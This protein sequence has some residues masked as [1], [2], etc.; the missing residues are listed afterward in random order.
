MYL[1]K[2][3]SCC[4]VV[5]LANIISGLPA[6]DG[7]QTFEDAIKVVAAAKIKYPVVFFAGQTYVPRYAALAKYIRDNDFGKVIETAACLNPNSGNRIVAYLWEVNWSEVGNFKPEVKTPVKPVDPFPTVPAPGQAAPR[8]STETVTPPELPAMDGLTFGVIRLPEVAVRS[9][10]PPDISYQQK[11]AQARE[12]VKSGN[13]NHWER[14]MVLRAGI[15][16]EGVR[17]S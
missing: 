17:W 4:G 5:D 10:L 9:P 13:S 6:K 2:I 7:T 15:R 12:R 3:H 1:E 8:P 14:R 11:L 16:E